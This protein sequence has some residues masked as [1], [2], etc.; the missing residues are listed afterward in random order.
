[1]PFRENGIRCEISVRLLHSPGGFEAADPENRKRTGEPMRR[2]K[3]RPIIQDRRNERY[4]REPEMAATLDGDRGSGRSADLNLDDR[5]VIHRWWC[6][7][8]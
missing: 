3:R 6:L 2:G 7:A 4:D 8:P 5:A 1:M